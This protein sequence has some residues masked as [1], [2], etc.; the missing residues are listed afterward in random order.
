MSDPAEI[1]DLLDA[2]GYQSTLPGNENQ[3]WE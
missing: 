2:A 3:L 1:D